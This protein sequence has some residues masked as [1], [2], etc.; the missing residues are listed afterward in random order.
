MSVKIKTYSCSHCSRPAKYTMFDYDKLLIVGCGECE[1]TKTLIPIQ[2]IP[3][4]TSPTRVKKRPTFKHK[5]GVDLT[6]G[7]LEEELNQPIPIKEVLDSSAVA[8]ARNRFVLCRVLLRNLRG[9]DLTAEEEARYYK[10]S[11]LLL[12]RGES[13]VA[14][15]RMMEETEF[16]HL[17]AL[18]QAKPWIKNERRAVCDRLVHRNQV[19]VLPIKITCP[20]CLG[21]L[22]AVESELTPGVTDH[23][24]FRGFDIL[25]MVECL[26]DD[27]DQ[28]VIV[29]VIMNDGAVFNSSLSLSEPLAHFN[30]DAPVRALT[31]RPFL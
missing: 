8:L 18:P 24:S 16:I 25:Q 11:R 2:E 30:W 14:G 22:R 5:Q 1:L 17:I 13:V 10:A 7:A 29:Q 6:V 20:E 15:R 12:E 4:P 9:R 27:I 31:I 19:H 21:H 23:G 28:H 26:F 3:A